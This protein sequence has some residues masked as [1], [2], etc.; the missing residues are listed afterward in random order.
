MNDRLD[1]NAGHLPVLELLAKAEHS[2]KE[3]RLRLTPGRRRVL[4][5]I[6]ENRG[7]IGAY[8]LLAKLREEDPHTEPPTVYRALNFLAKHGLVHRV[9]SLNAYTR[10]E[11]M[12]TGRYHCQLLICDNCGNVQDHQMEKVNEALEDLS[13]DM[14]FRVISQVIELHGICAP[15]NPRGSVTGPTPTLP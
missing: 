14:G 3:K 4:R 13:R 7:A 10:C 1:A 5:L 9:E 15:C 11:D 8:G 6:L 2:C 12:A